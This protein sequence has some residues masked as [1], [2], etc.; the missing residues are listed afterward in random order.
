MLTQFLPGFVSIVA[1]LVVL[2]TVIKFM[3]YG[4]DSI[5]IIWDAVNRGQ[6]LNLVITWTYLKNIFH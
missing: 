5:Y 3:S 4:L 2:A 1:L 6:I